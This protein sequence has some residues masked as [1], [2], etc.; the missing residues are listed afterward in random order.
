MGAEERERKLRILALTGLTPLAVRE[1]KR[2]AE[3]CGATN[4]LYSGPLTVS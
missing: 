2:E 4:E 1:K 3:S